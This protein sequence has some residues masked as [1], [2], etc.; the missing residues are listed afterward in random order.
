MKGV[1]NLI[2]A[3][4]ISSSSMPL[5]LLIYAAPLNL[6]FLIEPHSTE[7]HPR[8]SPG[9]SE[10]DE[11]GWQ[12]PLPSLKLFLFASRKNEG[13]G[14]G[15]GATSPS[16]LSLLSMHRTGCVWVQRWELKPVLVSL[17]ERLRRSYLRLT[18][19]HS[20]HEQMDYARDTRF[21]SLPQTA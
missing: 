20:S 5:L 11:R 10:P 12:S 2:F 16:F 1:Q 9:S 21:F 7:E 3:C 13:T 18:K 14:H 6:S 19:P 4:H 15:E 17:L 8:D